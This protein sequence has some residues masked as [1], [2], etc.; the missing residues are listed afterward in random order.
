MGVGGGSAVVEG[1]NAQLI[2]VTRVTSPVTGGTTGED[3]N[4]I[5]FN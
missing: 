4:G 1:A 3:Y 5:P 2:V